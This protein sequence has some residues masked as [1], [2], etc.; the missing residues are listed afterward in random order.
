VCLAICAVNTLTVSAFTIPIGAVQSVRV[1]LNPHTG[2]FWTMD[3][4]AGNSE[5]PL[6]L[7]KYL[8]CQNNPVNFVDPSGHEGTLIEINASSLISS[9]IQGGIA[10]VTANAVVHLVLHQ[11]YSGR[12]FMWD[13]TTGGALGASST[14][15]KFL[16]GKLGTTWVAKLA[17]QGGRHGVNALLGTAESY[18]KTTSGVNGRGPGEFNYETFAIVFMINYSASVAGDVFG[19]GTPQIIRD[20]KNILVDQ[21]IRNNIRSLTELKTWINTF[22]K[23]QRPAL[24]SAT[25]GEKFFYE[26]MISIV[27]KTNQKMEGNWGNVEKVMDFM[28][29]AS[30]DTSEASAEEWAS[31]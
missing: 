20:Q 1:Y 22:K 14:V 10:N 16:A 29:E 2:R 19:S 28:Q 31:P 12:E 25:R 7:H 26:S 8:Y 24:E 5:D 15:T 27:D 18:L 4:Y 3:T 9:Y 6:S 23:A 11:N 17:L 13:F 21:V 30:L